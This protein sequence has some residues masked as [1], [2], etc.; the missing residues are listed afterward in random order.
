M[1]E[2]MLFPQQVGEVRL[3]SIPDLEEIQV[4]IPPHMHHRLRSVREH[5]HLGV[6]KSYGNS[7]SKSEGR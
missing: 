3:A 6:V 4:E 1:D 2:V 5:F 7:S